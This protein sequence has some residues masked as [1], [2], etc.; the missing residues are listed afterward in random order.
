[1]KLYD[2]PEHSKI[3]ITDKKIKN[4]PT[5]LTQ[6]TGDVLHFHHIDGVYSLCYDKERNPV[7]IAALTEV[8]IVN[9]NKDDE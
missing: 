7:Y 5:S 3:K 4:P 8:E 9:Q 2:V 6:K 1:M